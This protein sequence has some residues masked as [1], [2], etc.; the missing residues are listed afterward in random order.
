MASLKSLQTINAGEGV[1]QREHSCTVCGNVNW[2]NL[3]RRQYGDSLKKWA[4]KP[5][6][7]PAIPLIGIYSEE[8]KIERDTHIPLLI[9]ALFYN[10]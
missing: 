2:Y 1:E 10:S 6:Y 5:P 9:A 3:Y 8:T 7:D 4:I